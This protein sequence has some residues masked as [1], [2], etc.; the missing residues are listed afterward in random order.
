MT[1]KSAKSTIRSRVV[2]NVTHI[3]SLHAVD[4]VIDQLCDEHEARLK[5]KDL[6]IEYLQNYIDTRSEFDKK[7]GEQ[8]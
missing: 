4:E 8:L 3:K 5:E 7:D 2:V 6:K 1:R